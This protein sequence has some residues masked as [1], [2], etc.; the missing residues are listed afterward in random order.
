MGLH[1][2]LPQLE[3]LLPPEL[4]ARLNEAQNDPFAEAQDGDPMRVYNGLTGGV[5][6]DVPIQGKIIRVSRRK[7]RAFLTQ[8]LNIQASD[9]S[10]GQ[11]QTV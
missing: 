5:L 7:F 2:S 11:T 6:M 8:G 4:W 1:W 9:T 3:S 10:R